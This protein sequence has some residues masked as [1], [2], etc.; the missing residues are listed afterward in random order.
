M[1]S[2]PPP[3]LVRACRRVDGAGE[4]GGIGRGVSF[5]GDSRWMGLAK[6]AGQDVLAGVTQSCQL[7]VA[8]FECT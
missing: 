2:A 5:R 6:V 8:E 3:P 1:R 4:G 7:Y